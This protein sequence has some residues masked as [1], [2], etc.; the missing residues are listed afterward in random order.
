MARWEIHKLNEGFTVIG[1][2][3][4]NEDL[5]DFYGD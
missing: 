3:S 1:K 4:A 2:S 5:T